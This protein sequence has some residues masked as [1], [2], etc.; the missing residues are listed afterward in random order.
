MEKDINYKE[1]KE[2]YEAYPN[3]TRKEMVLAMEIT[4]LQNKLAIVK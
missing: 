4:L 2:A 3:L 1:F